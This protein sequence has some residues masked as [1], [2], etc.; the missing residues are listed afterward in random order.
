M[1]HTWSPR[2]SWKCE[3]RLRALSLAER[4]WKQRHIADALGV[5]KGTVSKWLTAARA[6]GPAALADRPI[7]GRP[8]RL[9][10]AQRHRLP[11]FLW[12]GPE[13]C[14]FRGEVW[15]CARV[16]RVIEREFGVR[17]HKDHVGRLLKDLGWTPQVPARR[18]VQRDEVAIERWRE[19]AWPALAARA[20]REGRELMFIDES[21]FYLLPGV[22]RTYGP[23]GLT[24]V[25][26]QWQTR[27][28][29]SVMTGLTAGGRLFTLVRERS[30][31]GSHCAG[32]LAR[33]LHEHG[34]R[35]LVIWDGSPIHRGRQVR[36]FLAAGGARHVWLERLPAYAPELNPVEGLWQHLKHVELRNVVCLDTSH[37]RVELRQAVRRIRRR[38]DLLR[39]FYAGAGLPL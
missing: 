13:A 7:P 26:Y 14:G 35:W 16:A 30:L 19:E 24:P 20:R 32:F 22:V 1:E 3:R 12:H 39:S 11:D 15:T 4:G 38:G 6:S 37:L 36:G 2:R 34:G 25:V 29:L 5:G 33:L 17:Y 21:G 10:A 18:A 23:A 27:D 31:N 28:H 9:T 8:P